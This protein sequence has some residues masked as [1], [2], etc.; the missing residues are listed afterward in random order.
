MHGF[1]DSRISD[2]AIPQEEVV[3]TAFREK[4]SDLFLDIRSLTKPK[5]PEAIRTSART[6]PMS[7]TVKTSRPNE[8]ERYYKII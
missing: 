1:L 5:N 7:P 4:V 6:V 2:S 3:E 8:F